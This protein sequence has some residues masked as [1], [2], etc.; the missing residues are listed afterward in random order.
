MEDGS[1]GS[2][3]IIS[4]DSLILTNAHVVRD[5]KHV[6]VKL[7]DRRELQSRVLG[8]DPATDVAVL[9]I[10]AH[11]LPSVRL[12]SSDDL[13]VGD[14]VLAI[15]QPYGFEESATAGIVSAKGRSLPGESSVPFI[16]T[17][18][19]LN[20]GNSGGPL[21]DASGAVIGINA[22]IS[23]TTGGY[24]GLSFAIQ[25]NVALNA[26]NQI[27]RHGKVEHAR[28]G[29]E[30]QSLT[31]ELAPS[32]KRLDTSGALVANQREL[33]FRQSRDM[34][35]DTQTIIGRA[36]SDEPTR[37]R[38]EAPDGTQYPRMTK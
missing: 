37:R 3:F 2:D 11:D 16:Q 29:I 8:S 26:K 35:K 38:H 5:A 7:S 20:P 34:D 6:T 28:F 23:T 1:L 31:P 10:D 15:G 33:R 32:F 25:I 12:G 24:E 19:A 18:V 30:V 9:K 4:S 22:Q 36:L 21:F 27:V 13:E 17:D 14:Y